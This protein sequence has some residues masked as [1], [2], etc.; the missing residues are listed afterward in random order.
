MPASKIATISSTVATGRKMK[1]L[2]RLMGRSESGS[3]YRRACRRQRVPLVARAAIGLGVGLR[4]TVSAHRDFRA[5][6]Q[7]VDAVDH[8]R[9]AGGQSAR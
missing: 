9:V 2:D 4:R 1:G 7:L 5:G 3:G 6:L 8:D